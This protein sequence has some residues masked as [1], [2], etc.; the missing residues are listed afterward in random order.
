MADFGRPPVMTEEIIAKLE[1][2]FI[3][4]LTDR[5]AC[6]FADI[7]PATLYRYCQDNP[8]FSERKELLKEQVKM[9]AK[10]NIAEGIEKNDKPLSQ[11]YLETKGKNDGFSKRNEITGKDGE[12]IKAKLDLSSIPTDELERIASQSGTSQEGVSQA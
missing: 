10:I 1:E 4:G 3:K 5:E 8:D 7:H 2:G 11:W 6:L 12:E 9:R